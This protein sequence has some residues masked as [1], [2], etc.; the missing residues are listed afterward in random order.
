[1]NDLVHSSRTRTRRQFLTQAG[2][3]TAAALGSSVINLRGGEDSSKV[4]TQTDAEALQEEQTCDVVIIGAGLSG[5][6]TALLLQAQGLDVLVVEAQDRVG[7][8]TLTVQLDQ[9]AFIDHGGQWVSPGQPKIVDLAQDLGVSLFN[10]WGDGNTVFYLNGVRRVAPGIFLPNEGGA[11]HATERAARVLAQMAADVPIDFPW[12]APL[13][14][15]WDEQTL[16]DWLATHVHIERAR[17]VL[18]T[19][20]QGIFWRNV[21]RTS[22]LAALFWAHAGDPLDPFVREETGPER[23]FVGG[24]QQLCLLMAA[25]LGERVKLDRPVNEVAQDADGVLVRAKGL[26][27]RARY[28]VITLPPAMTTRLRYLPPLPTQ[29]DH[30]G[31]HAPMHWAIKVHCVYPRRFWNLDAEN[32]SGTVQSDSGLFRTTADNS[33]PSG[34]PGILVGFIEETEALGFSVLSLDQRQSAVAAE[35]ARYFG[36]EAANPTAYFEK[37]WGEDAFC[38]GIDGSYWSEGVWTTYGPTIREPFGRL[39]WAGTETAG[40]WN[41]KMEGALVSAERVA[42]EL[43]N[44]F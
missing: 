12:T 2:V 44:L 1:M 23:R 4:S 3:A 17:M 5:L 10:S 13:A 43:L 9:G 24:A 37:N 15:P 16:N 38:R 34:S 32:L 28:A 14:G 7:G 20:I 36:P 26:E 18:A 19:A 11:K 22:L 27:V 41:G 31:Q 8:R 29:R 42:E 39:H 6:R 30:L 35:F 40:I 21:S 25:R 33:P